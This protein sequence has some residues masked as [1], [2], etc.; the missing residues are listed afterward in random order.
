MGENLN[1]TV[2]SLRYSSGSDTNNDNSTTNNNNTSTSNVIS[3]TNIN[4]STNN[5]DSITTTNVLIIIIITAILLFGIIT[6]V[7]III[8]FCIVKKKSRKPTS[9]FSDN[10]ADINMYASPAYGTHHVFAE[11]GMDHLYEPIHDY[12]HEEDSTTLQDATPAAAN[13][14][15]TDVEGHLNMKLS[16]EVVDQAVDQASVGNTESYTMND[17]NDEYVQAADDNLPTATNE[18]DEDDGYENDDQK[19][20]DY[21]QLKDDHEEDIDFKEVS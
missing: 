8:S 3:S 18:S 11:S 12:L 6:I 1:Y 20:N 17:T 10:A 15:E 14:G 7:I 9:S 21:L 13:D 5:D 4:T 16:S 19:K 2:G